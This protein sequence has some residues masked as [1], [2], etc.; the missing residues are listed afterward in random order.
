[1]EA[2]QLTGTAGAETDGPA[3][4]GA[5]LRAAREQRGLT[6]EECAVSLR[7]RTGQVAAMERGDLS[8]FG[9]DIYA[10]GFLRSYARLVGVDP[11]EVLDLHGND[12][13]FAGPVLP[14]HAPLRLRREA[15]GWLLGLVGVIVVAGIITAVL[16]LGGRRVPPAVPPTDAA[17][18][19]PAAPDVAAPVVPAPAPDPAPTVRAPE[20]TGPPVDIV[21]IFERTSWLEVLVDDIAVVLA[22]SETGMLVAAGETLR[23]SGQESV[24]LRLGNAGGVRV[25]LNG[26]ELGSAGRPGEVV[27]VAYGPDGV[28]DPDG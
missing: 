10:R 17:L 12:P 19:A 27:R 11:Q 13:L 9:G 25:E 26:E 2:D 16:G 20:P 24:T 4:A 22:P 8:G 15:P 28:L 21:L 6:P 23:F 7:A 5:I 1:M 14:E 18:D 3:A